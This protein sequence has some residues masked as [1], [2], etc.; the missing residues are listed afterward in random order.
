MS[1]WVLTM[2]LNQALQKENQIAKYRQ[3]PSDTMAGNI[4][5]Q[6]YGQNRQHDSTPVPDLGERSLPFLRAIYCYPSFL[7]RVMVWVTCFQLCT[8]SFLKR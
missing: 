5:K 4:Q 7:R 6:G 8:F 1:S 2:Q 3:I